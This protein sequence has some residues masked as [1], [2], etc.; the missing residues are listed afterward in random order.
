MQ[1]AALSHRIRKRSSDSPESESDLFRVTA[2]VLDSLRASENLY[3]PA[4]QATDLDSTAI[5]DSCPSDCR[6]VTLL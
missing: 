6:R 3:D 5:E 2:E 1:R 4:T